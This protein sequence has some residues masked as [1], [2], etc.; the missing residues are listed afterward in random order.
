[1]SLI[2]V[3]VACFSVI[4]AVVRVT[5]GKYSN[6]PVMLIVRLGLRDSL[7]RLMAMGI[8][9]GL[10]AQGVVRLP[11]F[12]G[13]RDEAL[14]VALPLAG[15]AG[16]VVLG[17]W[18]VFDLERQIGR[19]GALLYLRWMN[20]NDPQPFDIKKEARRFKQ[21]KARAEAR[22]KDQEKEAS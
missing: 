5:L 18:C 22:L 12:E 13:F 3:Y 1:M 8:A 14:M 17:V 15:A 20:R 16:L 10:V 2:F 7:P 4:A 21:D 11:M 19:S 6:P 9:T